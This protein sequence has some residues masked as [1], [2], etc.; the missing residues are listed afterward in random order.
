MAD[1]YSFHQW[2]VLQHNAE[3]AQDQALHALVGELF[4]KME[5]EEQLV[6]RRVHVEGK[7]TRATSISMGMHHS[8]VGR[9][10]K[11]AEE[12]LRNWLSAVLRYRELEQEFSRDEW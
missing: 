2:Q 8:T 1:I 6:L 11:K 7:S 10:Q 12:K 9:L 4:A 5:P 3:N